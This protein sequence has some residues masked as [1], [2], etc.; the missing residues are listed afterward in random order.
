LPI[1]SVASNRMFLMSDC[2]ATVVH[3]LQLGMNCSRGFAESAWASTFTPIA[4]DTAC[5]TSQ[6]L[7]LQAST[8]SL[9]CLDSA[10]PQAPATPLAKLAALWV[11]CPQAFAKLL[12]PDLTGL[13]TRFN[14]Q[15][16]VSPSLVHADA[17]NA[18]M[19]PHFDVRNNL[20]PTDATSLSMLSTCPN[21]HENTISR[22]CVHA[23]PLLVVGALA[24]VGSTY[25][26]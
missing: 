4:L 5:V 25:S 3:W 14:L 22:L 17:N 19:R 23:C 9:A 24:R 11:V 2:F 18:K 21:L 10:W 12:A 7:V 20:W 8:T 6:V 1:H 13:N 26:L 16:K 15:R